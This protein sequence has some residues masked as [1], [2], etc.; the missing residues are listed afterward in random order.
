MPPPV[1]TRLARLPLC[2]GCHLI[3]ACEIGDDVAGDSVGVT[4]RYQMDWLL[5]C[6][7]PWRGR[8]RSDWEIR[9][10]H[11]PEWEC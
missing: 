1:T 7:C 11:V 2:G 3:H 9:Q 8:T 10:H 5:A 6:T 4:N